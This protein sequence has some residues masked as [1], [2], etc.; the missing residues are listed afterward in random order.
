MNNLSKLKKLQRRLSLK[1]IL[2]IVEE[3]HSFFPD[4]INKKDKL[5]RVKDC[6]M[7]G[8][9]FERLSYV[10]YRALG[11]IRILTSPGK[12]A[13][14]LSQYL[15]V[16]VRNVDLRAH[17][18]MKDKVI[19]AIK[20]EI[21][22][23]VDFPL[24]P[25]DVLKLYEKEAVPTTLEAY[26]LATLNSFFGKYDRTRYWSL[27]FNKLVEATAFPWQECDLERRRFLDKLEQWIEEEIVK[28]KLSAI[29]QEE[30]K[31]LE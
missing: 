17:S 12:G 3:Y 11:F 6:I 18:R 14:E 1:E 13:L 9:V 10:S 7:Q 8:I 27:R 24:V 31:K 28:D 15:N 16:K 21:I 19:R 2:P 5:I 29:I 4:W 22:P 23:K 30:R 25:I 20:D 26:S